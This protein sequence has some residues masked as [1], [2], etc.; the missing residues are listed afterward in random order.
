MKLLNTAK[1]EDQMR[2]Y[3]FTFVFSVCFVVA[4]NKI[5]LLYPVYIHE[6]SPKADFLHVIQYM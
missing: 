3:P 5:T 6:V 1:T 4:V 2:F